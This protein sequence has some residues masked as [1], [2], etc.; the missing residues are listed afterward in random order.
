MALVLD[1]YVP[2]PQLVHATEPVVVLY[3]PAT[4]DVHGPS[5]G[6]VNPGMQRLHAALAVLPTGED[7][8]TGHARHAG[9]P[10]HTV[11]VR[12]TPFDIMVEISVAADRV[13][14]SSTTNMPAI[15]PLHEVPAE[16]PLAAQVLENVRSHR[17][18]VA[19]DCPA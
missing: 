17:A 18:T 11:S 4:Q 10:R 9:E 16:S 7:V 13:R 6:P 19:V 5:F 15:S 3:L 1:E 8:P 12:S 14:S 2:A